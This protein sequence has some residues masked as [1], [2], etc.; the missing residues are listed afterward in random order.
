MTS[1]TSPDTSIQ[2]DG[3]AD[4]TSNPLVLYDHFDANSLVADVVEHEAFEGFGRYI[5]P[6]K[7]RSTYDR[8]TRLNGIG[9]LLPYHRAIQTDTTVEVVNYMLDEVG[10]ENT[11]FYNIYD[12]AER[13][14]DLSKAD[15]GIFFFRG[16]PDAPFAI[17]CAGG[18]FSYV[19]SIHESFPHALE[20]SKLGYNAFA[21]EY[22]VGSAQQATEDLAAA[23]SFIF[24]N[25]ETLGVS[26][27]NYSVWG[28]SAGARM[29]ANMGSYG[30]AYFGGADLPRPAAVF[31]AYTGHSDFVPVDVPTFTMV[32][33]NDSIVNVSTVNQRVA[34]MRA[35]GID[36]EYETYQT[37]GHGFGLG[38][39][40]DAEG[41]LERAIVFWEKYIS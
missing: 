11:I 41:W 22:R 20:L 14:A 15:T 16:E 39:G 2:E 28:G 18:G 4:N 23:I 6:I 25:S 12:Q 7:T 26:T 5:L 27:E 37:A 33:Q 3:Q 38:I 34:A 13:Q 17:V 8:T 36:V 24:E 40:T 10:A 32:S 29:A 19:G 1:R 31:V 30:P 9:G 21:I 35:A